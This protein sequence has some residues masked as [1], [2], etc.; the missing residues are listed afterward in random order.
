[1]ALVVGGGVPSCTVFRV[2]NTKP[3]APSRKLFKRH[4]AFEG[5]MQRPKTQ[6]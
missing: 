2:L 6:Y 1:M 4:E 5:H 3:S